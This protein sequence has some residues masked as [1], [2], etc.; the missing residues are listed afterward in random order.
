MNCPECHTQMN[1]DTVA[2]VT[3]H[4]CPQCKGMWFDK[5]ELD[6]VK[7]EVMPE[8]ERSRNGQRRRH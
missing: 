7:D 6:A 4:E 2:D 5:G 3:I 1:P 8:I